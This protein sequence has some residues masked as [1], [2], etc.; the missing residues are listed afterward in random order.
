MSFTVMARFTGLVKPAVSVNPRVCYGAG[1]AAL[2]VDGTEGESRL[3]PWLRR[4]R[5]EQ[6][7]LHAE[8]FVFHVLL[9]GLHKKGVHQTEE[10][11]VVGT[12][13]RLLEEGAELRPG[14]VGDY[15]VILCPR[16]PKEKISAFVDFTPFDFG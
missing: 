4:C 16:R 10:H 14:R 15:P 6:N 2:D 3:R 7:L 1:V 9:A 5:N 11:H 8:A 12:L 13:H